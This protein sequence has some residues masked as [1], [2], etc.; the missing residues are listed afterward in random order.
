MPSRHSGLRYTCLVSQGDILA[1]I[2]SDPRYERAL[3]G[4]RL[5]ARHHVGQLVQTLIAWRQNV[6]ED[7]KK[8]FSQNNVVNASGVCKR[9]SLVHLA[10]LREGLTCSL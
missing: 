2:S 3:L 1:T 4:I 8:N 5:L 7:I 6:N 9:V 10:G